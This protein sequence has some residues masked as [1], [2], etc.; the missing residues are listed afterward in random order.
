[1]NLSK[2]DQKLLDFLDGRSLNTNEL[3]ELFYPDADTRP[4]NARERVADRLRRLRIKMR[5]QQHQLRLA[6]TD[7]CGPYPVEHW[8]E[9]HAS[10]T[11][12]ASGEAPL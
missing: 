3:A 6:K 8:I 11:R 4:Y 1:M 5:R 2:D 10:P 9:Q 12:E 7:R